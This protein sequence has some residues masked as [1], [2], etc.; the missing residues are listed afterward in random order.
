MPKQIVDIPLAAG[1][2][3]KSDDKFVGNNSLLV[4]NNTAIDNTGAVSKRAGFRRLGGKF[5]KNS[6]IYSAKGNL[7]RCSSNDETGER[8]KVYSN[9]QGWTNVGST[10]LPRPQI[11]SYQRLPVGA[12]A[13]T[14]VWVNGDYVAIGNSIFDR[15]DGYRLV[16]TI[17]A[18][19]IQGEYKDGFLVYDSAAPSLSAWEPTNPN[20]VSVFKTS[21]FTS[22]VISYKWLAGNLMVEF[23]EAQ[24][25]TLNDAGTYVSSWS[26]SLS[27]VGSAVSSNSIRPR[28]SFIVAPLKESEQP[29]AGVD[30][31]AYIH[32]IVTGSAGVGI[33]STTG[34]IYTTGAPLYNAYAARLYLDYTSSS[35]GDDILYG[36]Y[37]ATNTL[38]AQ[39]SKNGT[40]TDTD[41]ATLGSNE[42]INSNIVTYHDKAFFM[43]GG[44]SALFPHAT[45]WSVYQTS[46]TTIELSQVLDLSLRDTTRTNTTAE[47]VIA[48]DGQTLIISDGR[49][50]IE[51]DVGNVSSTQY[52]SGENTYLA[53]GKPMIIT[54]EPDQFSVGAPPTITLGSVTSGGSLEEGVYQYC[55]HLEYTDALGNVHRGEVSNIATATTTASNKTVPYTVNTPNTDF[56]YSSKYT[57]KRLKIYRTAVNGSV[58][59]LLLDI[60]FVTSGAN[61]GPQNDTAAD[62][63]ITS[64]ATI[65]T[66]GG[67][68]EAHLPRAATTIDSVSDRLFLISPESEFSVYYT[69]PLE[70]NVIPEFNDV[71]ETN[72]RDGGKVTAVATM[73]RQIFIFKENAIFYMSGQGP[74]AVGTG[75]FSSVSRIPT[76]F[77][78]INHKSV[79]VTELGILYQSRRGIELLTRGLQVQYFGAPVYDYRNDTIML[80]RHDDET[81]NI[82]F[83]LSSGVLLIFDAYHQVWRTSNIGKD[84]IA[85]IEH[86]NKITV[87]SKDGYV[88][89][90]DSSILKDD[91]EPYNMS[92]E[93]AWLRLMSKQGYQ[94]VSWATLLG[95]MPAGSTFKVSTYYDYSD[96]PATTVTVTSDGSNQYRFKPP[97]MKCQAVRYKIEEVDGSCDDCVFNMLTLVLED[98]PETTARLSDRATK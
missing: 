70:I 2:D 43:T 78:C 48:I 85:A 55:C 11:I 18:G 31:I 68:L 34:A 47:H 39:F 62:S 46:S 17:S 26:H 69:K 87:M 41:T 15:A 90:E 50:I 42:T 64:N 14:E 45:L 65:Y 56:L 25:R 36:L 58:F 20:S 4:S 40:I 27:F 33:N 84:L 38:T 19:V 94:R 59:Y 82:T 22:S 96:T 86:D 44:T 24:V 9:S 95:T 52:V 83:V 98:I 74:S 30:S 5:K 61:Y 88:Y 71:L 7:Y 13:S 60:A 91:L 53:G 97:K 23:S 77:G 57:D 29:A 81:N 89:I 3:T 75:S 51:I 92:V 28:N 10:F 79:V 80:A 67:V 72:I 37:R 21:S 63:T 32:D 73:D 49:R 1:I 6:L 66:T 93:T 54:T 76:V 16:Y 8:L 12:T 35:S